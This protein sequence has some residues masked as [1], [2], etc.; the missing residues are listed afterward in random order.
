MC[1]ASRNG[2]EAKYSLTDWM[3][4]KATAKRFMGWT[5]SGAPSR[6]LGVLGLSPQVP[7][8]F[9]LAEYAGSFHTTLEMDRQSIRGFISN[10]S[11]LVC[12]DARI[13]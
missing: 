6:L 3:G 7:F 1:A 4:L 9:F 8:L 12:F 13:L 10:L 5:P 11:Q 2:P